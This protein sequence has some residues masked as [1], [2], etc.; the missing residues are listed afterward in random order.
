MRRV[1]VALLLLLG[2]TWSL[3]YPPHTLYLFGWGPS[4]R[5]Y[6]TQFGSGPALHLPPIW[7]AHPT[8]VQVRIFLFLFC[9]LA[10][11][12]AILFQGRS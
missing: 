5:E 1:G 10:P 6:L 4:G 8:D 11:A 3:M 9:V 12:L 2:G 7:D